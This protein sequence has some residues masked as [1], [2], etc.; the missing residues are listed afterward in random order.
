MKKLKFISFFFIIA[1]LPIF[2]FSCNKSESYST[3]L[4]NEEKAV[5]W[6]LSGQK[7]C[8]EIPSDSILDFGPDAPFYKLNTDGT[9]YMKVLTPGNLNSS[10]RPKAGDKVYYRYNRRNLQNLQAGEDAPWEGNSSIVSSSPTFFFYENSY[11]P[12]TLN[13]GQGIQLPLKYV[14]YDSEVLLVMKASQSLTEEQSLCIPFEYDIRY[15]KA[16]Y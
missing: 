9:V 7:V 6:F 14:G 13:L 2:Y 11:L 8:V 16:E 4:R 15:F 3:L 1:F 5:N 12:N 10:D